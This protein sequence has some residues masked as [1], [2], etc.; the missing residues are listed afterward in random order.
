MGSWFPPYILSIQSHCGNWC[1]FASIRGPSVKGILDM[2]KD[3]LLMKNV[4]KSLHAIKLSMRDTAET[5]INEKLDEA[6][7]LIEQYIEGGNSNTNCDEI[8]IAI[9]KVLDKLPSIVSLLKLFSD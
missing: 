3:N 2:S 1:D 5:G 6:I 8:I 9:G 7:K 4:L